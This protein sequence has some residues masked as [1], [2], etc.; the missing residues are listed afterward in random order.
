MDPILQRSASQE[1]ELT[2]F[3]IALV[4]I[5]I[6]V[7]LQHLHQK[8]GQK[9]VPIRRRF[10]LLELVTTLISFGVNIMPACLVARFLA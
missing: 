1:I 3:A 9:S 10:G 8:L 6:P 5:V 2:I 7:V 4:W